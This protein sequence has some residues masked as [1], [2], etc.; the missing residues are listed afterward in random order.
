MSNE[1]TYICTDCGSDVYDALGEMRKRCLTCQWLRD[2][3]DPDGRAKLRV[4]LRPTIYSEANDPRL[5]PG[6]TPPPKS[7]RG[8]LSVGAPAAGAAS[9]PPPAPTP[10]HTRPRSP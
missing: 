4:L 10:T 2:I 6:Y 9:D 3:A 7:K 8:R 5:E 1:P